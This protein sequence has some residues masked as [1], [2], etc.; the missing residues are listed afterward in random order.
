EK[1]LTIDEAGFEAEL[2]K[3]KQRSK[4]DSAA[5]VYDWVVLEEKPETFVGYDK[6]ENEVVITRYRKIENKDG[7]F[8]QIVLDNTPFYPEGG[9]QVGDK[10]TIENAV[11]NIEVL[12]TKKENNLIISLVKELPKDAGALFYAEVNTADRKNTQAN[13]SVTHLLHEA[14]RD[15]LGT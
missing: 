2:Q 12:E 14:L 7:E 13:H 4:K 10:G 9:G 1:G 11:E 3:Q 8:Y 6:T 15:V 5:K